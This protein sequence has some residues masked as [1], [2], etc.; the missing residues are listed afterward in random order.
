MCAILCKSI[1]GRR[2]K[3]LI[4]F[5]QLRYSLF[6]CYY[7]MLYCKLAKYVHALPPV[8]F[9]DVARSRN[10]AGK[11]KGAD[12]KGSS[13]TSGV[14]AVGGVAP[15]ELLVIPTM[16][17][18]A[19]GKKPKLTAIDENDKLTALT[20]SVS[21]SF[22]FGIKNVIFGHLAKRSGIMEWVPITHTLTH[23]LFTFDCSSIATNDTG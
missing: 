16:A 20:T 8:F 22:E 15:F 7:S 10:A 21:N 4:C 2:S 11:L 9:I 1:S 12:P 14:V 13:A 23:C 18:Y 6:V 5:L 17:K 19:Q 3:Q